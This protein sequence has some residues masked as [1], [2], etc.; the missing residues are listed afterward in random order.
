MSV[1]WLVLSSAHEQH[2]SC[3]MRVLM[4]IMK[5]MN[6]ISDLPKQ[7]WSALGLK[8]MDMTISMPTNFNKPQ[9]EKINK[10]TK[11]GL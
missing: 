6:L 7:C 5:L 10:Q 8:A 1:Q 2:C 4:H 3:P 11:K 9:P